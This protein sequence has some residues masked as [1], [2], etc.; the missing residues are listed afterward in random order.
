MIKLFFLLVPGP[1][2]GLNFTKISATIIQVLW[3]RPQS[4]NGVILSYS[5]V[6]TT[7]TGPVFQRMVPGDQNN[8]LVTNLS[9]YACTFNV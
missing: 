6:M 3:R 5:I 9:M 4:T 1:V 2:T 7:S 8:V